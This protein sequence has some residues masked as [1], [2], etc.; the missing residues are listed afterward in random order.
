LVGSVFNAGTGAN[1]RL[2]GKTIQYSIST[3]GPEAVN[4]KTWKSV[5]NSVVGNS[6]SIM[7]DIDFEPGRD[8]YICWR[9]RDVV[10]NDYATS[11]AFRVWVNSAPVISIRSPG[12]NSVLDVKDSMILD[13]TGKIL[14][15]YR[16]AGRMRQVAVGDLDADPQTKEI[17]AACDDGSVYALRISK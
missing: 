12:A 1:I 5:K 3:S 17:V 15:W 16:G 9:A 8:N 10:G 4:F 13:A 6:V 2:D 14:A 7:Q 11:E